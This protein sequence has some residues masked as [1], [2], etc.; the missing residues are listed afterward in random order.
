MAALSPE[1]LKSRLL[2][3][4]R[5]TA[6]M[7]SPLMQVAAYRSFD[8]LRKRRNPISSEAEG[9]LA[10]HYLVNYSVKTLTGPG[11]YSD[12]T[13][14]RVDLLANNN[15][16]Y[17]DPSCWAFESK[18]P[19]SPHFRKSDG[20]ICLGEVWEQ[21]EGAMLLGELLVHI[22]KLLNFDEAPRG[23]GYKGYSR[24]AI[25]YWKNVLGYAPITRN[26]PY[27]PLPVDLLY[28]GPF[29]PEPK[30]MFVRKSVGT[31]MPAPAQ[32]AAPRAGSGF[33]KKSIGKPSF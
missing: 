19:W 31:G 26:F 5:V 16:P 3:D 14:V 30:K 6:R 7:H 12:R 17:S 13:N 23:N 18:L 4:Y 2:L 29:K 24:E 27:P 11:V 32:P 22:A 1:E 10:T 21:S 15:Y 20:W 25:E 8:D 28:T 9:H 33:R